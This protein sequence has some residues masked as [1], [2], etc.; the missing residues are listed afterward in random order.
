[1]IQKMKQENM[2]ET[3][4]VE[5]DVPNYYKYASSYIKNLFETNKWT[6][7][8]LPYMWGTMGFIYN[9]EYVTH[10]EASTWACSTNQKFFNKT[11]IKDSVRDTYFLGIGLAK[12][13]E[14]N[15]KNTAFNQGLITLEDYQD[16]LAS[17]F[18]D[19]TQETVDK[20]E[21]LLKEAK[22]NA[23]SIEVD[24]GKDDM[25]T[26]KVWLNFA[27]SGD[28]FYAMYEAEDLNGVALNYAVP[29][30]GSNIWF[31]GWCM[32]KGANKKLACAFLDYISSPE[33]AW[34]NM[35]YI[36]YTSPIAGQEV[37]DNLLATYDVYSIEPEEGEEVEEINPEDVYAVDL[38]YYFGELGGEKAI[39]HVT[40]RNRLFDAQ[41]PDE[42]IINRCTIMQCFSA[43][44]DK[45]VNTMWNRVKA[46][47]IDL[48]LI[49]I[50]VSVLIAALVYVGY[51]LYKKDVFAPRPPKG[52]KRVA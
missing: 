51:I 14:L 24:S 30:E 23:F 52:Y 18:N 13:E 47:E 28:A 32:P 35:E 21:G 41:Y 29:K 39:V 31:D 33:N 49:V 46:G 26:G 37:F 4:D 42:E 22:R 45:R 27:W 8:A 44:E 6:D 12:R 50:G 9:P 25:I 2:L 16:Y 10:E 43:E 40:E 17:A 36:G 38:S 20:V 19:T 34:K 5:K 3:F 1:M 11:T 15:E 48:Y 7:I